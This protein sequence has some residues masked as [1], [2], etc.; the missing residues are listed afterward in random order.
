MNMNAKEI[1]F[2]KEARN[3]I[4][5][6]V[7]KLA[8]A[9]RVT[10]GPKGRNV[11][12]DRKYGSPVITKDGVSV[13]K[14]IELNDPF[15][16]IG[17]R[18]I[19]EVAEKALQEAGDGTTTST[20]LAQSI[21]SNGIKAIENGTNPIEIKRGIDKAAKEAVLILK[22]MAVECKDLKSI[23]QVATI[24]ANGEESVGK[25][26]A[27]AIN[28][29]GLFGIVNVEPSATMESSITTQTGMTFES[30]YLSN[31]FINNEKSNDVVFENPYILIKSG[32]INDTS[33]VLPIL[34][35]MVA[36]SEKSGKLD[37][38]VIIA[39]DFSPNVL[40]TLVE[41]KIRGVIKVCAIKAPAYA[42]RRLEILKDIAVLT[43]GEVYG[44]ENGLKT[45]NLNIYEEGGEN[46]LG[47]C[48]K[49][50]IDA[51]TSKI[52]NGYGT[53]EAIEKRVEIIKQQLEE[54]EG[55]F[56]KQRIKERLA[57]MA[58]GVATIR[59]GA[60]SEIELYEKI[61]RIDDALCATRAAIEEG[62]VSGG[63][64][65]LVKIA[66]K[67]KNL[68]GENTEQNIGIS[69]LL[70][71]FESPLSQ[72]VQNC[73]NESSIVL[74]KVKSNKNKNKGYNAALNKYCD[75]LESGI[76]DPAKVTRCAIQFSASVSSTLLT[77]ECIITDANE[78]KED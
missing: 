45:K 22:E 37:E 77:T 52:V 1:I 43:G 10:L 63:G 68:K 16:N 42:E 60:G 73:G 59:V 72:I 67:L 20:V 26:V 18:I 25:I 64:T 51:K 15:E 17:A 27:E 49:F 14:D 21:I 40:S 65:A 32:N 48:K 50:I 28:K 7:N 36:N 46:Y 76:L 70:K 47:R 39:D 54:C 66:D 44:L 24:S 19:K 78:E 11:I 71:S 55:D 29:V 57:K 35:Q 33:E 34:E 56:H 58:S 74:H 8:N 30:G 3:K 69:I 5:N 75:M 23:E 4:L 41:N 53:G 62:V 31:Y 2:N 61:D 12:I 13:A 6:G 38:L 9:V